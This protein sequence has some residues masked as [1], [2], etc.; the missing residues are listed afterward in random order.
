MAKLELLLPCLLLVTISS[1]KSFVETAPTPS[2]TEIQKSTPKGSPE[3]VP[4]TL[5]AN[6]RELESLKQTIGK[7]LEMMK[8]QSAIYTNLNGHTESH[9]DTN[10]QAIQDEKLI[11]N[12]GIHINKEQP[13]ADAPARENLN[14]P[15]KNIHKSSVQRLLP[16]IRPHQD[17]QQLNTKRGYA[18]DQDEDVAPMQLEKFGKSRYTPSDMAE[19]VFWTG[20]EKGVTLAIEEFLQAGLMTREEAIVFLQEIKYN[21]DYL[22]NHYSTQLRLNG[23]GEHSKANTE[24]IAAD[25]MKYRQTMEQ[26]HELQELTRPKQNK[27]FDLTQIRYQPVKKISSSLTKKS[28]NPKL[29]DASNVDED[30]DEL[31]DRLRVADFLYTEYSLEEIIY[32]LAKV[33]FTQGLTRGSAEAQQALRKFTAFLEAEAEQGHISKSLEKK[34]LD[35]L[36]ASL[37]DTLSEHPESEKQLI[38][39]ENR[40]NLLRKIAQMI[41]QDKSLH[42]PRVDIQLEGESRHPFSSLTQY[43]TI[44]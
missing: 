41:P 22:Q 30:Y 29:I 10:S 33:M 43:K 17:E 7:T 32:Q 23:A 34:V 35:V 25:L 13:S 42:S 4:E 5:D 6:V 16:D 9:L 18:G 44:D 20:D 3:V 37:T 36:I 15:E 24:N 2:P 11:S 19:Y 40:Q 8:S 14:I 27:N 21:L 31:M 26:I 1:E 28:E 38:P 12:I 39:H